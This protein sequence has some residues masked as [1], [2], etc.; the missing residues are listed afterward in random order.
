MLGNSHNFW[1]R[2]FLSPHISYF[3][4]SPQ[5]LWPTTEISR[6]LC[7]SVVATSKICH[8]R[9]RNS[10]RVKSQGYFVLWQPFF[11]INKRRAKFINEVQH[12]TR[13]IEKV[14]SEIPS[15]LNLMMLVRQLLKMKMAV[16]LLKIVETPNFSRYCK[17]T[18]EN[19]N[20]T[21]TFPVN[22]SHGCFRTAHYWW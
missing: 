20:V 21:M 5:P 17:S 18:K 16:N 14:D 13:F 1:Q 2:S 12:L 4:L 9:S 8:G 11:Q 22:L 7:S 3:I 15:S 19:G 10:S 6:L